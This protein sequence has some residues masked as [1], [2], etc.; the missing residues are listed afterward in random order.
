MNRRVAFFAVLFFIVPSAQGGQWRYSLEYEPGYSSNIA[1]TAENQQEEYIHAVR[2]G[3]RYDDR[4]SLMEGA[5]SL[6]VEH[7]S[8]VNGV[9]ADQN[10]SYLNADLTWS[11]VRDRLFWVME[12]TLSN[13]PVM[14]RQVWVPGNIQQTNLFSTGPRL[15]YRFDNGIG[16]LADI[17]YMNSYAEITDEFDS[18]RWHLA[19]TLF[20]D[21]S[22]QTEVSANLAWTGVDFQNREADDYRRLDI[23]AA[24]DWQQGRTGLRFEIGGSRIDFD[25]AD[26]V[27]GP[28]LRIVGNRQISS[29][30][31]LRLALHHGYSDAAQQI[32]GD[33]RTTPVSSNIISSQVYTINEAE[34]AYRLELIGSVL[35]SVLNYQGQDFLN[36]TE[37]DQSLLNARLVWSR[38]FGASVSAELGVSYSRTLYEMDQRKDHVLSP[39][40]G[41]HFRRTQRLGYRLRVD[42][43]RRDST[44]DSEDY[45][46]L[47]F[48]AAVR[49]QR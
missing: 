8:Y 45:D 40:A 24:W 46:E 31:Q 4:T 28:H 14:S 47:A 19:G 5:V 32:T 44:V 33:T 18:D 41:L 39:F 42:W 1:R 13:E 22:V 37:L 11:L 23:F 48:Y 34:M 10:W 38:G 16:L 21:I 25:F 3:L 26:T 12:D 36:G 20:Q 49:Y 7:L 43:E 27:F 35:E 17:R 9:F 29:F 6:D 15:S 2:L 30:S